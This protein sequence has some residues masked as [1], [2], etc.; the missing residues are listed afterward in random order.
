MR[1]WRGGWGAGQ[2]EGLENAGE[3]LTAVTGS[4][5]RASAKAHNAAFR[6]FR[7][8]LATA[9][10]TAVRRPVSRKRPVVA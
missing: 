9:Y 10:K 6:V 3:A 8:S 1:E 2:R 4:P 5:E 7:G